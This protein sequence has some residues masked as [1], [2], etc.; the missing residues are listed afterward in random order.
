MTGLVLL[1]FIP[2]KSKA[3]ILKH[4]QAACGSEL[5]SCS[6]F[7]FLNVKKLL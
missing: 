3:G 7:L 6:K 4:N 2:Y 5:Y 1:R